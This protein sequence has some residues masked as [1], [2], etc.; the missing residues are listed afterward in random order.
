VHAAVGTDFVHLHP[1]AD[2][3]AIGATTYRDFLLFCEKL[4]Q[5]VKGGVILNFGSAVILPEIFLKGLAAIAASGGKITRFTSANFDIIKHYRPYQNFVVR[6]RLLGAKAYH[7]TGHHELIL[8][9]ITFSLHMRERK[10]RRS[11][12][13]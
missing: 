4:R 11:A 9:L 5:C 6:P 12:A 3:A 8:P 2:G 10:E 13:Q 7:I 1:A